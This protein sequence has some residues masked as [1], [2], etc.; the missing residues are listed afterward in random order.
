[1]TKLDCSTLEHPHCYFLYLNA[2]PFGRLRL[3]KTLL[4]NSSN[5]LHESDLVK[6][7]HFLAIFQRTLV[8][9]ALPKVGNSLGDCYPCCY[10]CNNCCY[11]SG[12]NY[13]IHGNRI[14]HPQYHILFMVIIFV[15]SATV[16]D[17]FFGELNSW[18]RV[19]YCSFR[20]SRIQSKDEDALIQWANKLVLLVPN[21]YFYFY[22]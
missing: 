19:Y 2:M 1:V 6:F 15:S 17:W 7:F 8:F 3:Q 12:T 4:Y 22:F 14:N 13:L 20:E 18:P 5:N 10:F 11:F 21:L 16:R 9:L